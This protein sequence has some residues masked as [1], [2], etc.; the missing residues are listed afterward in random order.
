M[1]EIKLTKGYST[2]VDDEDFDYL[3]QWKWQY[4][5]GY[6]VRSE[7]LGKINGKYKLKLIRMHR[8]IMKTPQGLDTDHINFNKLDNQKY[9]LRICSK[10]F[11]SLHRKKCNPTNNTGFL[12]VH[13][14]KKRNIF[15]VQVM[16]NYK[17]FFNGRFKSLN[18]A[19]QARQNALKLALLGG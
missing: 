7:Y 12:G 11:N 14:N 10:S 9:N 17:V 16:R 4:A 5:D 3:N 18:E 13:F 15:Q 6:A 8:L 1:R 19:I 2:M